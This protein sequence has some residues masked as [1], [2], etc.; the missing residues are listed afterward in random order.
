MKQ[1]ILGRL[2]KQRKIR[3]KLTWEVIRITSIPGF[4][5]QWKFCRLDYKFDHLI[6]HVDERLNETICKIIKISKD[7]SIAL[8]MKIYK[9]GLKDIWNILVYSKI[10]VKNKSYK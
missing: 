7:N 4:N 3:K 2:Q 10:F 5:R 9:K 8:I 1:I 6:T